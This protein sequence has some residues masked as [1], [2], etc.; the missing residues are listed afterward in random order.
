[1]KVHL[2]QL[3]T[4]NY[5][6]AASQPIIDV[7]R[8]PFSPGNCSVSIEVVGD[9]LGV[10]FNLSLLRVALGGG[11]EIYFYL[12][13]WRTGRMQFVS[14][15]FSPS[16]RVR[17]GSPLACTACLGLM[18]SRC[19]GIESVPETADTILIIRRDSH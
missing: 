19:I 18:P 12:Y 5:H 13:N 14:T 11:S 2:I 8:M 15:V 4:S 10:L 16:L 1:M 9:T 7:P 3:S 6:P 17:R